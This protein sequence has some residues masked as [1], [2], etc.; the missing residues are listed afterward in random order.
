MADA[1]QKNLPLDLDFLPSEASGVGPPEWG[2]KRM[3]IAASPQKSPRSGN[4][5]LRT[6]R[7]RNSLLRKEIVTLGR[8]FGGDRR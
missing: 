7:Q 2:D 1:L 6:R 4:D 3:I 8:L 5:V